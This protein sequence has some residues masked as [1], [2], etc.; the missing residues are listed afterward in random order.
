MLGSLWLIPVFCLAVALGNLLLGAF[1]SRK[2][3]TTAV[4][5]HQLSGALIKIN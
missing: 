2:S 5:V 4:G 3:T 1:G